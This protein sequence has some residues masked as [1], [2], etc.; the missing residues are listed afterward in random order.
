MEEKT[1]YFQLN[2]KLTQ[3]LKVGHVESVTILKSEKN[4]NKEI[5][6]KISQLKKNSKTKDYVIVI[7]FDGQI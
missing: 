4:L 5:P 1:E 6:T 7:S 2:L 3:G